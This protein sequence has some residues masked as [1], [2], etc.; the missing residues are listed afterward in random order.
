MKF[1][2]L[3]DHTIATAFGH[4][5]HFKK[6]V[7]TY[8]PPL[9]RQAVIE[10]GGVTDEELPAAAPKLPNEPDTAEERKLLIFA[11]LEQIAT[12][13][14]PESFTAGGVPHAKVLSQVLGFEVKADERDLMWAEFRKPAAE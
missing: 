4:S 5:I 9:A 14:D 8:V 3:R 2:M 11:A 13:N 6:G 10:A 12:K 1:T 7:P